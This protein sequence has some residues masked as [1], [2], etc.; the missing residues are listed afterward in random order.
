MVDQEEV[1][2]SH[3]G[4]VMWQLGTSTLLAKV[5]DHVIDGLE[6]LLIA[7]VLQDAL[8]LLGI[9]Q[10]LRYDHRYLDA[11]LGHLE[12]TFHS[13]QSHLTFGGG[14]WKEKGYDWFCLKTF[15]LY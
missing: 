15:I 11:L 8:Q 10:Q 5:A 4:V 13:F 1:H 3:G 9:L 6:N 2:D 7:G 12:H 14:I